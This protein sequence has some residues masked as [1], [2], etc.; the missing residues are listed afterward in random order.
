MTGLS[1]AALTR[2]RTQFTQFLPDTVTLQ[3]MTIV[4]DGAGGWTETWQTVSGGVIACR[5]DVRYRHY[6]IDTVADHPISVTEYLL[7]VP[8]DAPLEAHQRALINGETYQVRTL[9]SDHSWRVAKRAYVTHM[10]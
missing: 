4:P 9:F 7:T 10:T 8:F 3:E 1:Q 2:M 5:L 6:P